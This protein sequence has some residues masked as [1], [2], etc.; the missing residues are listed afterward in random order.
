MGH[1]M[2]TNARNTVVATLRERTAANGVVMVDAIDPR[3]SVCLA[4][5]SPQGMTAS[6]ICLHLIDGD[7]LH[8]RSCQSQQM[9]QTWNLGSW[10]TEAFTLL[11][12]AYARQ[13]YGRPGLQLLASIKRGWQQMWKSVSESSSP[14]SCLSLPRF[15]S[16]R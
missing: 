8:L 15:Q 16:F 6:A 12:Q 14:L 7:A 9:T 10:L 4:M 2:N 5:A 1:I 3:P 13:P 11:P